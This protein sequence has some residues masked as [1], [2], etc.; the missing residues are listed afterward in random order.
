[1]S[2][3]PVI[4]PAR[5][6]EIPLIQEVER[7][8]AALFEPYG[9]A[10]RFA[11]SV[12]PQSVLQEAISQERLWVARAPHVVGFALADTLDG[13]AHLQELDVLPRF[14]R[15]GIGANLVRRIVDWAK[16]QSLSSV[17]LTTF[18]QVPWNAPWYERLGFRALEPHALTVG[19]S[20]VLAQERAAG[21]MVMERVAMRLALSPDDR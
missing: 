14:G 12:T 1:M 19:L 4:G 9:L 18:A 8:A 11:G 16:E 15:R 20:D 13:A 17:I 10:E 6:A 3:D 2:N 21:L 7:R 5:V